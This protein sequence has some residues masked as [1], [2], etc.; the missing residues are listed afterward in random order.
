MIEIKFAPQAP[1]LPFWKESGQFPAE[2]QQ[3]GSP[4]LSPE[5]AINKIGTPTEGQIKCSVRGDVINIKGGMCT[6]D[7][8]SRVITG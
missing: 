7:C 1:E 5:G 8:L 4:C 2:K 3:E 6:A